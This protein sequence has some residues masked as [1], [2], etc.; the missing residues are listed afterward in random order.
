MATVMDYGHI[1]CAFCIVWKLFLRTA[2]SGGRVVGAVARRSC[3]HQ[4]TV[5]HSSA[6]VLCSVCQ[7]QDVQKYLSPGSHELQRRSL[8]RGIRIVCLR[9]PLARCD[10]AAQK[11][12]W[13][14]CG[15]CKLAGR[16]IWPRFVYAGTDRPVFSGGHGVLGISCRAPHSRWRTPARRVLQCLRLRRRITGTNNLRRF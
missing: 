12:W 14:V 13:C 1:G 2:V 8:P 15:D 7:S 6:S 9:F 5:A 11:Y 4:P 3:S 16:R 10:D